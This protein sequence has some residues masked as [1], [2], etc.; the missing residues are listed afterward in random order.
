MQEAPDPADPVDRLPHQYILEAALRLDARHGYPAVIGCK[1]TRKQDK[2]A[3]KNPQLNYE[4]SC[5]F[6][7]SGLM[8]HFSI[9]V[10]AYATRTRPE[11]LIVFRGRTEPERRNCAPSGLE[12]HQSHP[13]TLEIVAPLGQTSYANRR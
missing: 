10:Q 12:D 13:R 6:S 8:L 2:R 3:Q 5:G 7:S 11:R 4:R 9:R 1:K